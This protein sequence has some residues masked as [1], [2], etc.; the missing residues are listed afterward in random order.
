M[1]LTVKQTRWI[2]AYIANNGNATDACR[3]AGY[4]GTDN[5][6]AQQGHDNLSN[7]QIRAALADATAKAAK[8]SKGKI[9]SADEVLALLSEQA[10]A[11]IDDCL[12][13]NGEPSIA[14]ARKNKA[15]RQIR[16]VKPTRDGISI[17]LA[18]PTKAQELLA[19]YHGLLQDQTVVDVHVAPFASDLIGTVLSVLSE[20]VPDDDLRA[21]ITDALLARLQG[22]S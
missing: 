1:P 11:D 17:K 13:Q 4:S 7:P 20:T 6:L 14:A 18:D 10:T 3:K 21:T 8:A 2:D 22:S 16:E 19:R 15:T 9:L 5:S 12:D